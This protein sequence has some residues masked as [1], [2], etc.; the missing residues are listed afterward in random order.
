MR[1]SFIRNTKTIQEISST[2]TLG[3]LIVDPSYQRRKVWNEQD[4]VRLI[5]TILLELVMPEVFFWTASRDPETGEAVTHI[6]DGQ[7]R[8]TTIVEFVNGEFALQKKHLLNERIKESC[9]DLNFKDLSP[10]FKQIVWEYPLSIVQIDSSCTIEDI[11]QMFYRLNLTEYSLNSAEKRNSLD[12]KFGDKCDA[13]STFDFWK[14]KKVFSS[15]DAKRMK[16][17]EYCCSIFILSNEGIV[18]QTNSKKINDY[19]DDYKDAFDEDGVLEKRV[20]LA[21]EMIDLLT[22]KT[23]ISF[24]SK[25]AQ[26]YTMFCVMFKLIDNSIEVDANI[27]EKFKLFVETYNKFRNEFVISYNEPELLDLY[28]KIKKYKLA[29]SEGIN[30]VGN[31]VIRFEILYKVCV[32]SSSNIIAELQRLS[33]DFGNKLRERNSEFDKLEKDDLEDMGIE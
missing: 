32:E 12:S 7:Q 30:K 2:F 26:M 3:K 16:D 1:Y 33:E 22:D 13:L 10:E 6:V 4:K 28:E 9:G 14:S 25:K 21:M 15:N 31:R 18:D 24:V 17:V 23:T 20:R 5:E 19:Y 29:S 8:I 11:K 27:F